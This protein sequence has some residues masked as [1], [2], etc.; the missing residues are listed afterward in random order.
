MEDL[1]EQGVFGEIEG[2]VN[3]AVYVVQGDLLDLLTEEHDEVIFEDHEGVV[4]DDNKAL[5]FVV[6]VVH[7]ETLSDT[8]G[9]KVHVNHILQMMKEH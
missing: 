2:A 4:C 8:K 1:L 7:S 6:P 5:L 9:W 3:Q